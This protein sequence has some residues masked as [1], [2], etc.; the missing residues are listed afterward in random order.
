M[1]LI[2]AVLINGIVQKVKEDG[3]GG[4]LSDLQILVLHFADDIVLMA[5]GEE[6]LERMVTKIKK[7][8]ED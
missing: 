3:D 2:F 7:Y 8:C 1:S 5:D 6:E 4:E